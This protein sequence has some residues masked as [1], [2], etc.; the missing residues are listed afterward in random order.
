MH[1]RHTADAVCWRGTCW[2]YEDA[3]Q[4]TIMQAVLHAAHC[5]AALAQGRI[6]V[7]CLT[8]VGWRRQWV[9][10]CVCAGC[11]L[12]STPH[13]HL[14]PRAPPGLHTCMSTSPAAADHCCPLP[15]PLRVAVHLLQRPQRV[16][17]ARQLGCWSWHGGADVDADGHEGGWAHHCLPSAAAAAAAGGCWR[18]HG[19]RCLSTLAA[20][21][22]ATAPAAAAVAL[23]HQTG[24]AVAAA[25]AARGGDGGGGG[26]AA[27][28][29][30]AAGSVR[31]A[32][33]VRRSTRTASS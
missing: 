29:S 6:P 15:A 8:A 18:E 28:G 11:C 32:S 27:A 16:A 4:Q 20:A 9:G 13:W 1:H 10:T 19:S 26:A 21:V 22:V 17:A 23:L 31:A 33:A 7:Q 3:C 2:G 30:A 5:C 12:H 24:A 25:A 14:R